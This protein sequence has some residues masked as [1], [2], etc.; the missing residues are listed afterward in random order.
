MN[1]PE[2]DII[3]FHNTIIDLIKKYQFRDRNQMTT[4]G[5]QKGYYAPLY[6][7]Y[8]PDITI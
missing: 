2:K 6:I 8:Y 7:A 1:V 4:C 5:I 3:E